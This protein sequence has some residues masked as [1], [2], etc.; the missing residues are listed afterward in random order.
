MKFINFSYAKK[1][2]LRTA[3]PTTAA[4]VW[5]LILNFLLYRILS[6]K[7]KEK[8]AQA[9]VFTINKTRKRQEGKH[10]FCA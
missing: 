8:L 10:N 4:F 7:R 2:A 5:Q 1:Q 6:M 9:N 3:A